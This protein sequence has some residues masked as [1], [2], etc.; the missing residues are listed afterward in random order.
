MLKKEK[1]GRMWFALVRGEESM[2]HLHLEK[3]L[4]LIFFVKFWR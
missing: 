1:R 3:K 2:N 4:Y